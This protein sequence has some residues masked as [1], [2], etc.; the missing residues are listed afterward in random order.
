MLI[1]A[2]HLFPNAVDDPDEEITV[3]M[4]KGQALA[5]M[6]AVW[7]YTTDYELEEGDSVML[8]DL[9]MNLQDE[10]WPEIDTDDETVD[11]TDD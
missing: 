4:T 1:D 7:A 5:L 2:R 11:E 9:Y 10:M 6:D 3:T 8:E